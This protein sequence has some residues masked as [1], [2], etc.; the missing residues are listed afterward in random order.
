MLALWGSLAAGWRGILERF[1]RWRR[2]EGF[3]VGGLFSW[4]AGGVV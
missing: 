3:G 2:G 4:V 1:V